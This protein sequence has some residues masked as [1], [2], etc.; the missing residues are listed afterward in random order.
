VSFKHGT[1]YGYTRKKCR[2]AECRAAYS[3][4][5]RA[6]YAKHHQ[7]AEITTRPCKGKLPMK[8]LEDFCYLHDISLYATLSG[9]TVRR[10]RREGIPLLA[11]DEFV[12]RLGRHPSEIWGLVW[13]T[14]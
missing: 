1:L 9:T 8:E 6:W 14:A 5:K 11:A 12:Y 2:C 3:G 7:P 10:W 13:E 4:Y